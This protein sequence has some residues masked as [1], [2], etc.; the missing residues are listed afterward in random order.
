MPMLVPE[1]A[2]QAAGL[3]RSGFHSGSTGQWLDRAFYLATLVCAL[4]LPS[5]A[6]VI[7]ATLA[8]HAGSSVQLTG[9]S[10]LWRRAWNPV[11]GEYGSLAFLFG[12]ALSSVLAL[13][14][15]T[16]AALGVALFV[17]EICPRAFRAPIAF[18]TELLAAVPS[19]V[20]GLW[21]L[22]VLVPMVRGRFGTLLLHTLGWTGLFAPPN[23]GVSVLTASLVLALM[24]FPVISAVGREV[25]QAVPVDQREA[26]LALG[27]TRWEMIRTGVLRNARLGLAGALLLGLG[28]A[29]GET[30]AVAMVI[31]SH[32][33]ITHNLFA[34][35][36]TL[37]SVIAN[38]FA[39]AATDRHL[40]ALMELGL[41]L[42]AVTTLVNALAR[43][44]VWLV[45]REF[46]TRVSA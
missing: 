8:A 42:F 40:S 12:T 5:I 46:V 6:F 7:L 38:E 9:L 43:L 28:R 23:Y 10:F 39:E 16:P 3:P 20:Y 30:M 14:L 22:L 4:S 15:A 32:P 21:A 35:G 18:I 2:T 45:R 11:T 34:P 27:A 44:L 26:A 24:V 33:S 37:G 1:G 19:V 29:L 41:V 31:G 13:L 36:Y 17:V 25:L